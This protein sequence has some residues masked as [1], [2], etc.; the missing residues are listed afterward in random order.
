MSDEKDVVE[1]G[2]TE[3]VTPAP[4][5]TTAPS[6]APKPRTVRQW[7]VIRGGSMDLRVGEGILPETANI[8]RA[9]AGRPHSCALLHEAEAPDDVVRALHDNLCAA[10]FSVQ[11]APV[12]FAACDLAAVCELDALLGE[13]RVTCD[14]VVVMVGGFKALSVASF[15]CSTWCGGVPLAEV[16][17]D[18]A[19]AVAAPTTPRALDVA[20]MSRMV[21]QDATARFAFVDLDLLAAD[22]AS[23]EALLAFALMAQTAM[24]DSDRSF[25]QLWDVADQL[26]SGDRE[27][28]AEQLKNT[29]KSRGKVSSAT[30]AALRQ[31][32]EFGTT[33]ARALRELAP[34]VS[35]ATALA[36]G[37]RFATRLGVVLEA[38][39]V[40]D[41]LAVDELLER[42]GIGT[43]SATVDPAELVARIR[44]ERLGRTNRFML[45]VPRALGR[46]RLSV[47]TDETIL[48]HASAWCAS[49]PA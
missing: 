24:C 1:K 15:A 20:G 41:M 35:A 16:P 32:L 44:D 46:V 21:V 25:G 45:A 39:S 26:A 30:S 42:L 12:D 4:A 43:T 8:L 48:E 19:S 47:M 29:L 10:G 36:D 31:S 18:I 22:P 5:P 34:S 14:D 27:A 3:E 23:D 7:V 40:D 2:E 33:F 9:S 28:L 13:M 49:R 11:T 37:M 17:L 6:P 38:L